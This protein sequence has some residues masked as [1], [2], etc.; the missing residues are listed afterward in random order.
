MNLKEYHVWIDGGDQDYKCRC[1]A[2]IHAAIRF[3]E[4][5]EFDFDDGCD[6]RVIVS[7]GVTEWGFDVS[8]RKEYDAIEKWSALAA[9]NEAMD[10]EDLA[11]QQKNSA[12]LQLGAESVKTNTS[13]GELADGTQHGVGAPSGSTKHTLGQEDAHG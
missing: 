3:A 4:D 10:K 12:L 8:Q 1:I 11:P 7:D 2:P 5:N 9:E 13:A 6:E